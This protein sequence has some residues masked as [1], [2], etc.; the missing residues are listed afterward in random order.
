MVWYN[1]NKLFIAHLKLETKIA[2]VQRLKNN[3]YVSIWVDFFLQLGTIYYYANAYLFYYVNEL[4]DDYVNDSGIGENS[5]I[6]EATRLS[7]DMLT[8][9]QLT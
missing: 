2:L 3:D 6:V 9:T 8:S 5:T 1:N 7:L 4:V